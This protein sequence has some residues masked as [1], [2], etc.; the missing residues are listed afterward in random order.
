MLSLI[1]SVRFSRVVLEGLAPMVVDTER[2]A[3]GKKKS[4]QFSFL[5]AKMHVWPALQSILTSELVL[6]VLHLFCVARTF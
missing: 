6:P 3:R 1:F 2:G 4:I 5:R